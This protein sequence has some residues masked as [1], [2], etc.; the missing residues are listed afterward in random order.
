MCTLAK[1][2]GVR[3]HNYCLM[4]NHYHILLEIQNENLSRYMRQLNGEYA[5]YF[6]KKH[7]R[8]G[9]L[10]QGRFKSWYVTDEAYLLTLICY[11]EQNPLKAGIVQS[12]DEYPY[13]SYRHL[14][15]DKPPVCLR[16][17]WILNQYA[18]D[19]QRVGEILHTTV[20]PDELTRMQKASSLIEAPWIDNRL[21][22]EDLEKMFQKI[23]DRTERN[24]A[25]AEA[26]RRG[27]SQ[28]AIAKTL[29]MSQS[30]VHAIIKKMER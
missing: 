12:L 21:K 15:S 22:I 23:S 5:I 30:T 14:V 28:H 13:S 20:N 25:I 26:Y 1:K 4:S 7:K 10:W 24:K 6:N 19:T 2:F 27:Y 18:T 8:V 3:L 17:S 16:S 29:G 11:I 9:H